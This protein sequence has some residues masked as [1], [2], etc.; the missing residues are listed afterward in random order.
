MKNEK[1]CKNCEIS[2]FDGRLS[3]F[4]SAVVLLC[5]L[6]ELAKSGDFGEQK[7]VV[8]IYR[9][10]LAK[11]LEEDGKTVSDRTIKGWLLL[12][13]LNGAI[14]YKIQ[15]YTANNPNEIFISPAFY[16]EGTQDEYRATVARW[17]AFKSDRLPVHPEYTDIA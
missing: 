10:E 16:F 12:L 14:K 1:I 8:K 7:N 15:G 3:K 13:A 2:A 9:S 17:Y 6:T 4:R 11:A 5:L